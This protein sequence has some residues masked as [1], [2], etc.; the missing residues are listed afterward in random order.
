VSSTRWVALFALAHFLVLGVT[1]SIRHLS[2]HGNFYDIGIMD[3]FFWQ[4]LHGRLFFY[5]Q[6]EMSY[7]GDH[8]APILFLFVPPY[9]IWPHALVLIVGQAMA[10]AAGSLFV[11]R[12]AV[13]HLAADQGDGGVA[14]KILTLLYALHPSLL[15][16]AMFDFHPVALMIPISLAAY[17]CYLTR[18]RVWLVVSLVVLAACQEEAAITIAAFGLYMLVFS[19]TTIDRW[20]GATTSVMAALYFVVV[21]KVIIPAFQPSTTSAGWTYL[22]RYAHLGS[23]MSDVAANIVLH[24][25]QSLA[26]SFE[27]YKLETLMWL[28]LPLGLLPLLGWRALLVALPSLTYSYLSARPGQFV[29]QHQYFSPALGWLVVAAAQGLSVWAALWPRR[30]GPGSSGRWVTAARLPLMVAVVAMIASDIYLGPIRPAFFRRHPYREDLEVLHRIIGPEASLSV[31][32]R[33]ASSFAHRREYFLALDFSLNRELNAALGLP[34][35]RDTQFHLFDLSA[36]TGSQDRERRV[37]E[38]L[39]DERYGVRYYRFPL[40]LFERGLARRAPPELEAL[41]AGDGDDGP[42]IVRAYPAIFLQYR[43]GGSVVPDLGVEG[44]GATMRFLPGGDSRV[45]GPRLTLPAGSYAVD[46]HLTLETPASGPVADLD[47]ISDPGKRVH[48]QRRVAGADFTGDR[49]QPF[50]LPIELAVE[51]T[52]LEFRTLSQGTAFRLCKVVLRRNQS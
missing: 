40:V 8:F 13:L 18:R 19:R 31:T 48:A 36:L 50:T 38:L 12:I 16:V 25:L 9:A 21:M 27:L 5:P 2:G 4:T 39:R 10:L 46:F 23:S 29:I 30:A 43:A 20:I 35:Y 44:R 28:F 45:S 15:F 49:C 22:S 11:H 32:N 33:L 6:Y 26:R 17:Y 42:G 34:N 47:V 3:N 41:V 37:A 51:T 14:P 52:S 1:A 7:F 24:P